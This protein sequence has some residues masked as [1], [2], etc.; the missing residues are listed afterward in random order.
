MKVSL[1]ALTD[2]PIGSITINDVLLPIGSN[3]L[4]FRNLPENYRAQLSERHARIFQDQGVSYVVDLGSE[5]GTTLN[6]KTVGST[7]LELTNGDRLVF[8][9]DLAY[10]VA[11]EATDF[12]PGSAGSEVN[13]LLTPSETQLDL[14]PVSI[15]QLPFM[16]GKDQAVL[17]A[18][19]EKQPHAFSFLSRR[20][21]QLSRDGEKILIEDLNSTNGTWVNGQRERGTTRCLQTGDTIAF[22]QEGVSFRFENLPVDKRNTLPVGTILVSK[23]DS[24]L[25]IYCQ[26]GP[27]EAEP[28]SEEV[29]PETLQESEPPLKGFNFS[30]LSNMHKSV[31]AVL[32]ISLLAVFVFIFTKDGRPETIQSLLA[33]GESKQAMLLAQAFLQENPQHAEVAEAMQ[34]AMMASVIPDWLVAY[35][36]QNYPLASHLIEALQQQLGSDE[37][38]EWT[39]FLLWIAEAAELRQQ[40]DDFRRSRLFIDEV[41]LTKL[42][43]RPGKPASLLTPQLQSVMQSYPDVRPLYHEALS[44]LR[45]MKNHANTYHPAIEKMKRETEQSLARED[46]TE[47]TKTLQAFADRYPKIAGMDGLFRDLRKF[48]KLKAAVTEKNLQAFTEFGSDLTFS[49]PLFNIAVQQQLPRLDE[50][51]SLAE[52][53]R[54][55]GEAWARGENRS[56]LSEMERLAEGEWGATASD[57]LH[58]WQRDLTAYETLKSRTATELDSIG[59]ANRLSALYLQL[60]AVD[61]KWLRQQV[62]ELL[63]PLEPA[64]R[65]LVSERLQAAREAW[66]SYQAKQ[67]GIDSS[68]RLEPR[69]TK[70]FRRQAEI[71]Q[72]ALK[73]ADDARQLGYFLDQ[74]SQTQADRLYRDISEEA[75]RQYLA[76]DRLSSVLEPDVVS[77]KLALI[78]VPEE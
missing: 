49:T 12:K 31:G 60:D 44:T 2:Q 6:G 47:L 16:V 25:D 10:Q 45:I 28:E 64:I 7:P 57:Q 18:W 54:T 68:M 70:R 41:S 23:A 14:D 37:Q 71:L 62:V 32:L 50:A 72:S 65:S 63:Q 73:G 59:Y 36:K 48:Q 8:G 76:L 17:T 43:D 55:A 21:A 27:S 34:Q 1:K 56:A 24:F 61:D 75:T 69:V 11:I 9:V 66:Q 78:P 38:P 3:E 15:Q 58:Q 26:S 40:T 30:Q 22:G 74:E 51:Q 4:A 52:R 67:G 19:A 39:G 13:L 42:L 53:F 5:Q 33:Q 35:Q 29:Q 20:H 46:F 77:A